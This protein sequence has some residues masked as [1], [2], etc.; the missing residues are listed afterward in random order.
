MAPWVS[1]VA[2]LL[3]R[4]AP[5]VLAD[6]GV[7]SAST[8]VFG[9]VSLSSQLVVVHG[10]FNSCDPGRSG[11]NFSSLAVQI[12]M[13]RAGDDWAPMRPRPLSIGDGFCAR[14][15]PGWR[16]LRSAVQ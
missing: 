12:D 5:E 8:F 16:L 4:E 10:S 14:K 3:R 2:A 11:M 1:R 9:D 15:P 6:S 13:Q 7:R